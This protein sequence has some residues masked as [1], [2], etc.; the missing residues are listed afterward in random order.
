[1]N[2]VGPDPLDN[3][4]LSYMNSPDTPEFTPEAR[5]RVLDFIQPGYQVD[6]AEDEKQAARIADRT[7]A[8]VEL[9]AARSDGK[10]VTVEIVD[11]T[12]RG[13][14]PGFWPFC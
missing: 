12:I 11:F 14:C 7:R 6:V 3:V 13:I 8:F 9:I 2:V 1:M 10:P 5:Q 4:A